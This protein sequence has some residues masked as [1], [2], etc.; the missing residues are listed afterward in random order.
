MQNL[1]T[2]SQHKLSN[3]IFQYNHGLEYHDLVYLENGLYKKALA[4]EEKYNVNG[5]VSEIINE[6]T[7]ILTT[8]GIIEFD[9][10]ELQTDSDIDSYKDISD[11]GILYLSDTQEGKVTT[12]DKITTTFYTPVGFY[13]NNSAI[14]NIMDSSYGGSL[15]KYD[16]SITNNIDF[17]KITEIDKNNIIQEVLNNAS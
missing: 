14:I 1:I 6:N 15:N 5:I 4:T 11:S 16:D 2:N 8:F 9:I 3:K 12:Y 13:I 7:F 10:K 17:K